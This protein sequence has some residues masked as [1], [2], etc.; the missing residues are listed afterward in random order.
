MQYAMGNMQWAMGTAAIEQFTSST[1][2]CVC[3]I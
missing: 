2:N 3:I 1:G